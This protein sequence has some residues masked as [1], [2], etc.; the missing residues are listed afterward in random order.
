MITVIA[1]SQSRGQGPPNCELLRVFN[2]AVSTYDPYDVRLAVP[3]AKK[4]TIRPSVGWSEDLG[5]DP[6]RVSYLLAPSRQNPQKKSV[7]VCLLDNPIDMPEIF[8]IRFCRVL[9][10]KR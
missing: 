10:D 8:F 9:V 4:L 7:R 2:T 5:T 6:V 1:G 3:F